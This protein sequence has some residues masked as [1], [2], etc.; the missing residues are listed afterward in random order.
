MYDAQRVQG[1][2]LTN[3]KSRQIS[4]KLSAI[5]LMLKKALDWEYQLSHVIQEETYF[6]HCSRHAKMSIL[7][8]SKIV[9]II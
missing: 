3:K 4:A 9:I 7:S 2:G 1:L 6:T 5:M 8:L